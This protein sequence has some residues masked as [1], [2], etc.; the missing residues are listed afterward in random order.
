MSQS[1]RERAHLRRIIARMEETVLEQSGQFV[2]P[3]RA[4]EPKLIAARQRL[5]DLIES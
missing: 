3:A 4:A 5:R 1:T 2:H